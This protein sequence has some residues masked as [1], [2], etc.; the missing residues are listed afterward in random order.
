MTLL[1]VAQGDNS[2][3]RENGNGVIGKIWENGDFTRQNAGFFLGKCWEMEVSWCFFM[4]F[5]MFQEVI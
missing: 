4:G 1:A 3:A 5:P 2:Q